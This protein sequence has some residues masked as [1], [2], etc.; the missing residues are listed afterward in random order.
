MGQSQAQPRIQSLDGL[1]GIAALG[2]VFQHFT[3]DFN[4]RYH[5]ASVAHVAFP[6]GGYGVTLFFLISGFV[7]FMTVEKSARPRDFIIS[8]VTRLF[9]TYWTALA[10]TT[11]VLALA[12]LPDTLHGVHLFRRAVANV[13]MVSEWFGIG[14]V[15]QVYWTLRVEMSFYLI[16]L[17]LLA[18]RRVH[19]AIPVMFTLT[20][21]GI[22]H[23][24]VF[25]QDGPRFIKYWG[26]LLLFDSAGFF[27]A[28]MILYRSLTEWRPYYALVLAVCV[29]APLSLHWEP[30]APVV[31]AATALFLTG[32]V[33]LASR[34]KLLFLTHPV[35]VFLGAISYSL[36]VTHHWV[37]VIILYH[38]TACGLPADLNLILVIGFVIGLATVLTRW[39][40][41][42]MLTLT[43]TF[44]RRIWH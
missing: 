23:H 21:L 36:Y 22:G 39:I 10:I 29:A 24:V 25:G 6:Y 9:P 16:M 35:L 44:L 17:A 15:D 41:K 43:R 32:I 14:L 37:G 8:R 18:T 30:H 26:M 11:L 28:G 13:P 2:V 19:W 33:Y 20:L 4:E 31:D 27:T 5:P 38:L 3:T 42:P 40:E 1:R 12:P 7:I 34:D